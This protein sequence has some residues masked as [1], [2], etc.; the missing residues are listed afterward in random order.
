MEGKEIE[1]RKKLDQLG[2]IQKK[3][4]GVYTGG[5]INKPG[6]LS[7]R[8]IQQ[9]VII[10]LQDD[11]S[12]LQKTA[13]LLKSRRDKIEKYIMDHE[14][15]ANAKGFYNASKVLRDTVDNVTKI[16]EMKGQTL[17]EISDMVTMI[18]EKL[19]VNREKL[20]PIVSFLNTTAIWFILDSNS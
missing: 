20:Q 4:Q 1:I 17:Q 9:Q 19:R 10:S 11:C 18:S 13:D 14:E 2:V 8:E 16:D 12:L 6:S 7:K 5:A 15:H 3:T